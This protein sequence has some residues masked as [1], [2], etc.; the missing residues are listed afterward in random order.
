M[1]RINHLA[2]AAAGL[3]YWLLG[4]VWYGIFS[5]RFVKLMGWTPEDLAR[6]EAEGSAREL[7][8]AL[9]A[10]LLTAYALAH[11]V[12]LA[13]ARTALNG[14][15]TGFW[16]FIGFV[17]TTNLATVMFEGRAAGL[18]LI[19]MGY[20]LIAFVLM[21]AVLAVWRRREARTP[22]YQS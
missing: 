14:A 19:S 22:V 16:A 12:R 5:D 17:L 20:N 21:G 7:A 6:V 9:A 10:S 2:A 11:F 3:L 8:I 1:D 15:L 18:Y 4:A 13:G